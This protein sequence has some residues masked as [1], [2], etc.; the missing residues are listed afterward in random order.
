MDSKIDKKK[1]KKSKLARIFRFK[2]LRNYFQHPTSEQSQVQTNNTRAYQKEDASSSDQK[3]SVDV[4]KRRRQKLIM[5][6]PKTIAQTSNHQQHISIVNRPCTCALARARIQ[7]TSYQKPDVLCT[8]ASRSTMKIPLARSDL[9][10]TLSAILLSCIATRTYHTQ[11]KKDAYAGFLV[12]ICVGDI[13]VRGMAINLY[14]FIIIGLSI[15][16]TPILFGVYMLHRFVKFLDKK[17]E[18]NFS[19]PQPVPETILQRIGRW[20]K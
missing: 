3:T 4:C 12:G 9:Y 14:C 15:V 11:D 8:G 6:E 7:A 19:R 2:R 13:I 16:A 5:R 10:T 17:R 20:L 1:S 18:G